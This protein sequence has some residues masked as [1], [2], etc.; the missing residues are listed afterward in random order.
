MCE[1]T[2]EAQKHL[3]LANSP[4]L[5]T[6]SLSSMLNFGI[7]RKVLVPQTLLDYNVS[8]SLSA[9]LF[10]GMVGAVF[11]LYYFF[12][13]FVFFGCGIWKFPA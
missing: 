11:F 2:T 8:S 10:A 7:L 3:S 6:S 13:F 5:E 1:L 9:F 12:F 4:R